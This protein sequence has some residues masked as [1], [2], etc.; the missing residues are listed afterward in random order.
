VRRFFQSV[1]Q[2]CQVT[3]R[4]IISVTFYLVGCT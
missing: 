3:V 2:D 4:T 1:C